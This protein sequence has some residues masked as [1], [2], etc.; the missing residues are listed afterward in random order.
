M[1]Q[2]WTPDIVF[3]QGTVLAVDTE[4][5]VV[6][7]KRYIPR[8]VIGAI[9]D[10]AQVYLLT[11]E[12]LKVFIAMSLYYKWVHIYHN[13]CFDLAVIGEYTQSTYKHWLQSGGMQ[14]GNDYDYRL[15][16]YS[17]VETQQVF[18]TGILFQLYEIAT[19]GYYDKW[20]LG[21]VA[22]KIL[23]EYV[24]KNPWHN[25][26]SIRLNFGDY[27]DNPDNLPQPY[28]DYLTGDVVYTYR[29]YYTLTQLITQY[30]RD[31][32]HNR[33]CF[34]LMS[35]EELQDNIKKHGLLTHHIQLKASIVLSEITRNGLR[36][37]QKRLELLRANA[38]SRL[39]IVNEELATKYKFF[40][41][42][43]A[44]K[45]V[46]EYMRQT[47]LATGITLPRTATGAYKS[48]QETIKQYELS[49][50]S[51][52]F[53]LYL[54]SKGLIKE[55]E[56]YIKKLSGDYG[57]FGDTEVIVH[58]SFTTLRSTGRTSSWG[59][60]NA[61]NI[62][63]NIEGFR[64]CFIPK[65]DNVFVVCD[66]SAIELV[67]FCEAMARQFKIP[68]TTMRDFINEGKDI[69]KETA[70]LVHTIPV[71]FVDKD[72]RQQAKAV[73]FGGIGG[74]GGAK[75]VSLAR[76][77]GVTLTEQ[78]ARDLLATWKSIYPEINTYLHEIDEGEYARFARTIEFK[79]FWD[80]LKSDRENYDISGRMLYKILTKVNPSSNSGNAYSQTTIN[81]AWECLW[82]WSVQCTWLSNDYTY[83]IGSKQPNEEYAQKL[84][85][86]FRTQ[87]C[88]NMLG[89]FRQTAVFTEQRNNTFQSLAAMG[90]K[91][92][93]WLLWRHGYH[94][95]NFIHDEF[96][97]EVPQRSD[98]NYTDVYNHVTALILE[99]MRQII[100]TT[101]VNCEGAVTDSWSK[102]ATLT[103]N[104]DNSIG[105]WY[106]DRANV[107]S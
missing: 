26:K 18:D 1:P 6:D 39:K 10:G 15:D 81:D 5:T 22:Q 72:K 106:Y 93:M 36:I 52:F 57:L 67:T 24:E 87:Y 78:E 65:K 33:D 40:H 94:L 63:R 89:M 84:L 41:G 85:N 59:E 83:W 51:P 37:N 75:L 61:Q 27:V 8:Y 14:Y 30:L 46:Q 101:K 80:D 55:I 73:N 69:H 12:N 42:S 68:Q 103:Y 88:C 7:L 53:D 3:A 32:M 76:Q 99:G 90:A 66:Y 56:T 74:L 91:L 16:V 34:G 45:M 38:M 92:A 95:S 82:D 107:V 23:G 44:N 100:L 70:A 79:G 35:A 29:I 102:K 54:E 105:V 20:N 17:L 25:G 13:A 77:Y 98:N 96:L 104:L 48:D 31:R 50:Y 64:E 4:T 58:P 9:Y 47:E 71:D 43:G 97:V 11:R 19:K 62:P 21:Y 60:I 2:K 86:C 49:D 28:I